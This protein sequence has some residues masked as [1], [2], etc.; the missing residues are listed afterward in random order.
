M[1]EVCCVSMAGI[2]DFHKD[3]VHSADVFDHPDLNGVRLHI[4]RA[5]LEPLSDAQEPFA[6][7]ERCLYCR[8]EQGCS[9]LCRFSKCSPP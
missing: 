7:S 6:P 3:Q 5:P 2:N 1:V 9:I 8:A 4:S